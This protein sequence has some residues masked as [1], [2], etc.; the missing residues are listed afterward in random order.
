MISLNHM[1]LEKLKFT[2]QDVTIL[3]KL[4]EYKGR[5]ALYFQQTPEI[6]KMLKRLAIIE[7]SE[8][9]NRHPFK[10]GNGAY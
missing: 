7:S 10:D 9:S 6:L 2:N 1:V 8:S 4:G 5:Q 3:K